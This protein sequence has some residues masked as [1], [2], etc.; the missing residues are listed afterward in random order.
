MYRHANTVDLSTCL[1]LLAKVGIVKIQRIA[2][3]EK[4]HTFFILI[5]YM[6]R[7][8]TRTPHNRRKTFHSELLPHKAQNL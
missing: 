4:V 7:K 2:S 1:S 3:A 8:A 6:R 5:D